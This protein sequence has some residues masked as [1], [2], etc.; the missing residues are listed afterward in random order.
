MK[1]RKNTII[2][3]DAVMGL[4]SIMVLFGVVSKY[5]ILV[6][7]FIVG[8]GVGLAGMSIPIYL[9]EISPAAIRLYHT[10][11]HAHNETKQKKP[12]NK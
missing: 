6:S 3:S 2:L 9:T 7:R 12:C 5:L 10:H 8:I 1:G 11:T 4:G